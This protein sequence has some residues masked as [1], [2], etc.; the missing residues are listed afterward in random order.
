[1]ALE[2]LRRV[3]GMHLAS[4]PPSFPPS[5]LHRLQKHYTVFIARINPTDKASWQPRLNEE[6]SAWRWFP[7]AAVA[8]GTAN[9]PLHPVVALALQTPPHRQ[10]VLA[11]VGT[12][13]GGAGGGG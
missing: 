7:L 11:A 1:M 2:S 9:P 3:Y 8:Q 13:T 6:H 10:A 5:L 4:S 12:G